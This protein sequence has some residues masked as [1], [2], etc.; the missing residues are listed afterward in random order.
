MGRIDACISASTSLYPQC[1]FV[2]PLRADVKLG[3]CKSVIT[4]LLDTGATG[5]NYIDHVLAQEL[6]GKEGISP[7]Q[8]VRDKGTRAFNGA[9]GETITHQILVRLEAKDHVE[10]LCPLQITTLGS[11]RVILGNAWLRANRVVLLPHKDDYYFD[12]EE[13][14]KTVTEKLAPTA[15]PAATATEVQKPELREKKPRPPAARIC[16]ISATAFEEE[17]QKAESAIF[18]IALDDLTG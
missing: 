3:K 17:A 4:V 5:G 14:R 11:E 7:V 18:A 15:Q 9:Q 2:T 16:A 1:D 6:C 8:L 12:T 10:H 13:V